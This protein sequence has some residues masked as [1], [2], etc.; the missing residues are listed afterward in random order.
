LERLPVT[1]EFVLEASLKHCSGP[2]EEWFGIEF[3]ASYPGDYYQFLLNGNGAVHISKHFGKV[4]S[5]V[6]DRAGLGLVHSIGEQNHLVVVRR[7]RHIHLFVNDRH[8]VS[9]DDFDIRSG[10]P[11]LMVCRGIRVEFNDLRV[12]GVS[13]ESKVADAVRFWYELETKK[14]K[15]ILEYVAR[16]EPGF[17]TKGWPPDASSMLCEIRPDRNLTVLIAIGS[18]ISAQLLDRRAAEDLRD[19]INRRGRELPFRWAAIVTDGALLMD[20]VYTHCPIISVGGGIA[21]QF[22]RSMEESQQEDPLSSRGVHIQHSTKPGERLIALWGNTAEETAAAVERLITS[23]LLDTFL[24][25]IWK[26]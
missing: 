15:E 6:F 2:T 12:A 26:S 24:A 17:P 4:W 19:A 14:A 22:T 16:Y 18:G 10:T 5:P 23:N 1:S 21:N 7:E 13:L 9:L 20:Q 25:S 3:G 8:V 11:G